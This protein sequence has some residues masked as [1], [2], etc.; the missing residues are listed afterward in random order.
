MKTRSKF[1]LIDDIDESRGLRGSCRAVTD[2]QYT[3]K[4][5]SVDLGS[6][7]RDMQFAS[8]FLV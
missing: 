2:A 8:Y 1:Q 5:G 6:R 4:R 3:H 7:L